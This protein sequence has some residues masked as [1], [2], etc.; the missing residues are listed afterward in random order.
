[1]YV[2][3]LFFYYFICLYQWFFFMCVCVPHHVWC[4]WSQQRASDPLE[5]ALQMVVK[6][7][8]VQRVK[9]RSCFFSVVSKWQCGTICSD[10]GHNQVA[11]S[12]QFKNSVS[13]ELSVLLNHNK[14]HSTLNASQLLYTLYIPK[15]KD[16]GAVEGRET[17]IR[18]YFMKIFQLKIK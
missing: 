3:I 10:W 9:L 8:E 1:M 14:L 13:L 17:M 18:I 6:H 5:Q 4:L 2:W 12:S 16:V 7:C 15:E 11:V